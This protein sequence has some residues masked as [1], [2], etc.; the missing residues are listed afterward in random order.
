[1]RN[2][3]R[4]GV[5]GEVVEEDHLFAEQVFKLVQAPV[6]ALVAREKLAEALEEE[7]LAAV[8]W[9]HQAEVAL[10]RSA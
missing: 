9:A 10:L 5:V 4:L 3:L 8:G 1:M 2:V 7:A 6:G